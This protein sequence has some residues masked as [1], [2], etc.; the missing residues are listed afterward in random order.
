MSCGKYSPTVTGW[1]VR[2]PKWHDLHCDSEQW[3]DR[4]GYDAYG[5]HR[6]TERDRE[7]YTEWDYLG[8]GVWI[9]DEYCYPLYEA[10]GHKWWFMP[11]PTVDTV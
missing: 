10:V 7:G 5:Y 4:E 11:L 1:Y 6:E 9:G 8:S 2:D 3:Y